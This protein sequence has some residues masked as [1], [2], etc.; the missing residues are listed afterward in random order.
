MKITFVYLVFWL[1]YWAM[2]GA[3]VGFVHWDLALAWALWDYSPAGRIVFLCGGWV[4]QAV[5]IRL[6]TKHAEKDAVEDFMR[7][8]RERR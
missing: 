2:F 6:A 3:I 1:V 5:G 4:F 7:R 8:F